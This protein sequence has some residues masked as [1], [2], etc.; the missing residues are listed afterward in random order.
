MRDDV[1]EWSIASGI[2]INDSSP[3]K[4]RAWEGRLNFLSVARQ[5]VEEK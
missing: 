3:I 1:Y 2:A 4:L 5:L